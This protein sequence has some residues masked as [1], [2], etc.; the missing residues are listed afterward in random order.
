MLCASNP[1]L[2]AVAN[3]PKAASPGNS[4]CAANVASATSI[5][6][7]NPVS[8]TTLAINNAISPGGD[9]CSIREAARGSPSGY[10]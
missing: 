6:G 3:N 4:H 5:F 10:R 1:T 7:F 9:R 2:R 8:D